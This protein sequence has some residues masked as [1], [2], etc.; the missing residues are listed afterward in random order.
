M[1]KVIETFSGIGAQAKALKNLGISH[2][3]IGTADWDIP[4]SVC[5]RKTVCCRW[6]HI[7]GDG[8]EAKGM[9]TGLC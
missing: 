2:K 6:K 3:I 9:T 5:W 7:G 4:S 1:L 8:R